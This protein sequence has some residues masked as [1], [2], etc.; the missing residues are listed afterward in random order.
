MPPV[1]GA[2]GFVELTSLVSK[3]K[4]SSAVAVCAADLWLG[5]RESLALLGSLTQSPHAFHAHL[6][7]PVSLLLPVAGDGRT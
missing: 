3:W 5:L 4:V 7:A 6:C 1:T 2:R